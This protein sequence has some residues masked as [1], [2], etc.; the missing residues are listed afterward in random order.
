MTTRNDLTI[1]IPAKNEARL[2]PRLLISLT[3]QDYSK[4]SSTRVLVA[5]ANST[6]D[7]SCG[8]VKGEPTTENVHATDFLPNHGITR[9]TVIFG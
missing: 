1:V 2:I 8:I 7:V 4:M 3:N 5:D 6:D 9:F